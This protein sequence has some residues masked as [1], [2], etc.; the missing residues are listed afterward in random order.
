MI[1]GLSMGGRIAATLAGMQD[2]STEY[3]I[4]DGAPLADAE[5]NDTVYDG[6]LYKDYSEIQE[7]GS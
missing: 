1:C 3:L 6:E 7:K 5:N 2:I 4:L